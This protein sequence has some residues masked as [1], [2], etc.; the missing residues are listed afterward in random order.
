MQWYFVSFTKVFHILSWNAVPN[1]TGYLVIVGTTSGGVE[2]VNNV[3]V[4]NMTTYDIP[5]DVD[6]GI[7]VFPSSVCHLA[8]EQLGQKGIKAAIIREKG[9][10][11]DREMA[12]AMYLAGMDVKDVHMTDLI[13]GRENL[14]DVHM[15]V[16]VGGFSNSDV[17]ISFIVYIL[18]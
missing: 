13:S 3:D 18:K 11:G 4:G 9:V 14:E 17:F 6:M 15:I 5:D 10:N 8:L 16:F 1:A 12:Y 7:L 2:V